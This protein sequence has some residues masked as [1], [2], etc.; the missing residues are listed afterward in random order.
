MAFRVTQEV[1]KVAAGTVRCGSCLNIFDAHNAIV[2]KKSNIPVNKPKSVTSQSKRI[3]A[4]DESWA[5]DLLKEPDHPTPTTHKNQPQKKIDAKQTKQTSTSQQTPKTAVIEKTNTKI[6]VSSDEQASQAK[7]L[8]DTNTL[9]N[10]I[11]LDPIEFHEEYQSSNWPWMIGVTLMSLL[12]IAQVAWIRFDEL[13]LR[14]P[15][16]SHYANACYVLGC[17]LPPLVSIKHIQAQHVVVRS[18]PEISHALIADATIINRADF[19]QPYPGLQLRFLN[20]HGKTVASRSFQP[21]D[22]LRGDLMNASIMP[23][24]QPIQLSLAIVDPGESAVNYE[25]N[26]VPTLAQSNKK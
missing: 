25:M 17:Q 7:Q 2:D 14:R 10:N 18:H 8:S 9:L 21:D 15:Y 24:A 5:L 12:L 22:Y 16:R 23:V 26:I 11:E 4:N 20:I 1:L 3:D 6:D 19:E 13:S